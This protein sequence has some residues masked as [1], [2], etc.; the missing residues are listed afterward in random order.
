[1]VDAKLVGEKVKDALDKDDLKN[2]KFEGVTGAASIF[3]QMAGSA[4][5]ASLL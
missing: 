5:G 4:V 3:G 2:A 1:M